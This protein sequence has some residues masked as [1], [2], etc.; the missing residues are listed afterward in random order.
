MKGF[1]ENLSL[2]VMLSRDHRLQIILQSQHQVAREMYACAEIIGGHVT[3]CLERIFIYEDVYQ[4]APSR[5][6]E[7]R[8]SYLVATVLL[9][10][11]MICPVDTWIKHCSVSY[12]LMGHVTIH[13]ILTNTFWFSVKLNGNRSVTGVLRG[14]DPYM[15]LVLD[16][17]VEERSSNQKNK[18]GM[19]VS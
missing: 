3:F 10:F 19:V 4:S 8:L 6:E 18:I 13:V 16:E 9:T 14:F 7:V 15:N 5:A 2:Y 1:E 17:A 12:G 11:D